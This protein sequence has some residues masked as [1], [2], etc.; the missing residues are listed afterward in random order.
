MASA[1][2]FSCSLRRLLVLVQ[3]AHYKS[4]NIPRLEAAVKVY[5]SL[6]RIPSLRVECIKKLASMLLHPYPKVSPSGD[7]TIDEI[8]EQYAERR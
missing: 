5:A 1:Q 2:L 8:K 6:S 3:K 4:S 7:S